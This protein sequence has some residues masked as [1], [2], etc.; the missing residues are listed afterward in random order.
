MLQQVSTTRGLDPMV[1]SVATVL[2]HVSSAVR[3]EPETGL[4]PRWALKL[5]APALKDHPTAV[6]P[7]IQLRCV[8]LLCVDVHCIALHCIALHCIALHC[9]ALLCIDVR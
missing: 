8:A 2:D 3:R 7:Q 5:S 9:I 1:L 4:F 6:Q